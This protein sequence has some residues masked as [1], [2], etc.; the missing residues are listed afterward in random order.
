MRIITT[1]ILIQT[2]MMLFGQTDSL[3]K[4]L[5]YNRMIENEITNVEFSKLGKEW[6][7][8]IRQFGEYPEL[9]FNR[10][11]QVHFMYE[12]DYG[13]VVKEYLFNRTLEWLS[14]NYGLVPAWIYS[15]MDD[16]KI[17]F[18]SN[19]SVTDIYSF[20]YTGIISIKDGT[21]LIEF[22]NIGYQAFYEGY[23]KGDFWINE[24]TIDFKLETLYPVI[25]KKPSEWPLTF[26]LLKSVKDRFGKEVNNLGD[27][28]FNYDAIYSF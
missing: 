22:V 12:A 2:G 9:P 16:G 25:M 15:N 26:T 21:M 8:S 28:I 17:I 13:A 20:D 6:N 10:D 1:L 3:E 14:I 18:N 27:Y 19:H 5:L 4:A 11:G 23:Y 24:R 7:N